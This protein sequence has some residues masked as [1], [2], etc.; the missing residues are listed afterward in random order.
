M[1]APLD[2]THGALKWIVNNEPPH[3]SHYTAQGGAGIACCS[4]TGAYYILQRRRRL[5]HIAALKARHC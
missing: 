2:S 4:A 3:I 1:K 5:L